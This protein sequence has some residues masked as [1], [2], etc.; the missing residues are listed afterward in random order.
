[1]DAVANTDHPR[2]NKIIVGNVFAV[3]DQIKDRLDINANIY[4]HHH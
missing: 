1:M 3:D 4:N 2:L